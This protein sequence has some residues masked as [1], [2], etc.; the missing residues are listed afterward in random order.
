MQTETLLLLVLGFSLA[1][2]IFLFLGRGIW[3]LALRLGGRR[4]QKQVP[5]T[6]A[7]L[8]T[9]RD[10]LRAEYAKLTQKL[11]SRLDGIK[12]QMAEQM[13][14][15]T[16]NRNR[17]ETL[18]AELSARDAAITAAEEEIA[19]HRAHI[20][21]LE[22]EAAESQNLISELHL[23]IES[24]ATELEQKNLEID[25]KSNEIAALGVT[26]A[27]REEQIAALNA[28][29]PVGQYEGD[30]SAVDEQLERH[31]SELTSYSSQFAPPPEVVQR[32]RELDELV[33]RSN[34][35]ASKIKPAPRVYAAEA[36][37]IASEQ[38]ALPP[39]P[40]PLTQQ[41]E[42]LSTRSRFFGKRQE[43]LP[44]VDTAARDA[45]A[46]AETDHGAAD[47]ELLRQQLEQATRDL[48]LLEK[49]LAGLQNDWEQDPGEVEAQVA[50][51]NELATQTMSPLERLAMLYKKDATT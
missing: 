25:G 4:M 27:E 24:K 8:Q 38:Y 11:G 12:A 13:A 16:R 7:E 34:P 39:E 9:E 18:V 50:Q 6:V 48:E 2:I 30:S 20:A 29:V 40:E 14:E 32:E 46:A 28:P 26:I 51:E 10:R 35:Y 36:A 19:T 45:P 22:T 33:A 21:Q 37:I 47:E 1:A 49:D 3:S 44:E 41:A 5:S 42:T 17:I 31:L 23:E 15:V 43:P